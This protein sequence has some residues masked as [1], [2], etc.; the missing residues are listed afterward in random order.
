[1]ETEDATV[2]IQ[3]GIIN[4]DRAYH[5]RAWDEARHGR[6]SELPL[7][8][9]NIPSVWDQTLAPLGCHTASFWNLF[10]PVHLAEGAWSERRDEMAERQLTQLD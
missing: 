7:V 6:L 10:A 9:I 5:E 8:S 2:K 3:F 4:P 1:L